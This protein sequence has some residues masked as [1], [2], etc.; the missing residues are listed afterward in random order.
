[1]HF[2]PFCGTL[3]LVEEH[4]GCRLFCLTCPYVVLVHRPMTVVHDLSSANKRGR[5][6]LEDDFNAAAASNSEGQQTTMIRCE[7]GSIAGDYQES[8]FGGGGGGGSAAGGC[9][10]PSCTSVKAFFIQIQMRSA[11]EPPTTFYKCVECGFRWRSN[12]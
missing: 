12:D 11:D 6:Q 4:A 7:A 1:M 9:E 8:L 2:C 3:L 10:R 5:D